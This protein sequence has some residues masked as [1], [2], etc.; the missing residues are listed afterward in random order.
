[1]LNRFLVAIFVFAVVFLH[2]DA[3]RAQNTECQ[4][5]YEMITKLFHPDYA[6]PEMWETNYGEGNAAEEFSAVTL[7][8]DATVGAV[9]AG[10]TKQEAEQGAE[11]RLL[12]GKVD[13][14][15]R[16]GW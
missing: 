15:G 6:A 7:P 13:H 3:A 11:P 10:T 9:A 12:L 2:G 5:N 1:M 14:R 16:N 4:A 8:V